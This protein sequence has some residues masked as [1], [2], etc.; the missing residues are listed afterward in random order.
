LKRKSHLWSEIIKELAMFSALAVSIV[1]LWTSNLLLFV[2]LLV[3]SLVAM[4]FWH[5]RYDRSFLLVVAVL[6][7]ISEVVLYALVSGV[8][9][10]PPFSV[11]PFGFR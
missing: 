3:E 10:T 8:T 9:V 11:C 6:G 5:E 1:L 2:V 4:T 7:T